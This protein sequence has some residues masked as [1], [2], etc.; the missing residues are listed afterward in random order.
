MKK[1]L[2][3]WKTSLIGGGALTTGLVQFIQT[4]SIREA[5]PA[6]LI[7]IIGLLAKD[8]DVTGTN[9]ESNPK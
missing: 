5:I 9:N 1:Y 3:S 2:K 6:I 7:G 4:G 8:F